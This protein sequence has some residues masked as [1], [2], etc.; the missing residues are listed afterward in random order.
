MFQLRI[1]KNS[2]QF[3]IMFL[4]M[5][6]PRNAVERLVAREALMSSQ[7]APIQ[8]PPARMTPLFTDRR[9]RRKL[10]RINGARERT[11]TSTPLRELAPETIFGLLHGRASK[12]KMTKTTSVDGGYAKTIK[13]VGRT[14]TR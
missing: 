6:H 13:A 12:R 2:F 5:N 14:V 9:I 10:R 7:E 11:R 4:G 8:V 1:D 3:H